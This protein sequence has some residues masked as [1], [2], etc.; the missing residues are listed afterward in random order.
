MLGVVSHSPYVTVQCKPNC[1]VEH[2][3]QRLNALPMHSQIQLRFHGLHVPP[4]THGGIR[5][6]NFKPLQ[7]TKLGVP[8]QN[9][10]HTSFILSVGCNVARRLKC[11]A[12]LVCAGAVTRYHHTTTSIGYCMAG[13]HT[14]H[15][16]GV[17][18]QTNCILFLFTSA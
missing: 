2:T 16:R 14:L 18:V 17:I 12:L 5:N 3:N 4:H 8:F 13:N 15:Y 1:L 9:T 11:E 10:L 7:P 6:I